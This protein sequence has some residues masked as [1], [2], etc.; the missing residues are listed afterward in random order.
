MLRSNDRERSFF[1]SFVCGIAATSAVEGHVYGGAFSVT[2]CLL[3]IGRWIGARRHNVPDANKTFFSFLA[4][5]LLFTVIWA[6]YHIALPG[7]ALSEVPGILSETWR[8]EAA[9]SNPTAQVGFTPANIS[10]QLKIYLYSAP[11]ELVLLAIALVAALAR[12]TAADRLLLSLA[13]GAMAIVGLFFAHV[14]DFYLIFVF[15]I[16]AIWFGAWLGKFFGDYHDPSS[17]GVHLSGAGL[18]VL[19]ASIFLYAFF[20][21][22]R[23]LENGL[24]NH[25]TQIW[26]MERIGREINNLLPNEDVVVAGDPGYYLG[27]PH[28]L[29][30]ATTFSFTWGLPGYWAFDAP[31]AVIVTV[32][33]DDGY[34]NLDTWL[35]DHNFQPARCYS[36]PDLGEETTILYLS[37]DLGPPQAAISCSAEDLA[38]LNNR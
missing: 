6:L 22:A 7:L 21:H 1:W 23:S 3:W 37:P 19:L 16:F 24:L 13:V 26:E 20:F 18:F 9:I 27:M 4:G 35:V 34:S 15:P 28:R 33:I 5:C 25:R 38:W 31:Q 29:N 36:V 17:Q 11:V 8:W 14:N 10:L 32:G 2:F 30:Y 12:R